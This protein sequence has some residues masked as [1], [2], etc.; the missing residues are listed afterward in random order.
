MTIEESL[1]RSHLLA[2]AN[3]ELATSFDAC[4]NQFV[5]L[6]INGQKCLS[7]MMRIHL[8]VFELVEPFLESIVAVLGLFHVSLFEK[9]SH[10]S[11]NTF[12]D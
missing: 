4:H 1:A 11:I 3:Q 8:F 10:E 6:H 12:M 5:I 7:R 9:L 2:T